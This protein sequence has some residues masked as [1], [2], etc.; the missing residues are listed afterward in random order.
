ML[1]ELEQKVVDE[2]KEGGFGAFLSVMWNIYPPPE[3]YGLR[4]DIS[5]GKFPEQN[6]LTYANDYMTKWRQNFDICYLFSLP[7]AP[8]NPLQVEQEAWRLLSPRVKQHTDEFGEYILSYSP[9]T[10]EKEPLI[11]HISNGWDI[12]QKWN[13]ISESYK[14]KYES[15]KAKYGMSRSTIEETETAAKALIEELCRTA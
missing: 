9:Q 12:L 15:Y 14:A 5:Q 13:V 4:R 6:R 8:V 11:T 10:S 2:H 1:S 3:H 7:A